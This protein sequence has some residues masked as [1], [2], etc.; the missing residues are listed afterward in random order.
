[1]TSLIAAA[2]GLLGTAFVAAMAPPAALSGDAR[3]S[4]YADGA[5]TG[6]SGAFGEDSCHACHFDAEVN[7]KPGAVTIAGVPER[8]RSGERYELTVTLT[9]PGIAIG[10]FQLTARFKDGGAQAGLLAPAPGEEARLGVEVRGDVQ[11]AGQRRPGTALVA[12]DTA[13]WAVLWTA[14]AAGADVVF[15]AAANAADSDDS[16]SGDYVYTAA[17]EARPSDGSSDRSAPEP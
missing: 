9:R 12:A 14:P 16:A 15:H 13:R 6:F 10:G 2:W 8:F 7:A 5:P 1:V 17:R 3:R 11:Y 4:G